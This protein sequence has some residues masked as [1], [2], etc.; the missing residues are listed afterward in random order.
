MGYFYEVHHFC[1]NNWLVWSSLQLVFLNLPACSCFVLEGWSII[2]EL[3]MFGKYKCT[4]TCCHFDMGS[5]DACPACTSLPV[6][7]RV[8]WAGSRG[9]AYTKQSS[10]E[11]WIRGFRLSIT[12][13]LIYLA[14]YLKCQLEHWCACTS[15]YWGRV[16]TESQWLT[17]TY[18]IQVP[19]LH[20]S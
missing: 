9:V 1:Q 13:H 2:R 12:L 15:E 14:C 7:V 3:E 17:S 18:L 20:F 4:C 8:L 5:T 19:L 10:G 16:F 11:V 6:P